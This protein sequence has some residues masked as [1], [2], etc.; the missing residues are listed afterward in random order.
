MGA[1]AAEESSR[2]ACSPT[3][4]QLLATTGGCSSCSLQSGLSRAIQPDSLTVAG[5]PYASWWANMLTHCAEDFETLQRL[6]SGGM[7]HQ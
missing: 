2:A 7:R 3:K 1:A 6:C 4:L 5:K